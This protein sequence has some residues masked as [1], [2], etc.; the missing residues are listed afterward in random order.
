[1][2]GDSWRWDPDYHPT[3]RQTTIQVIEPASAEEKAKMTKRNKPRNKA[4]CV[5]FGFAR[6]LKEEQ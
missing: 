4:E 5:P 2:N 1:M 6:A 3:P